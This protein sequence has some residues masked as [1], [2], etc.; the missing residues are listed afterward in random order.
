MFHDI[1][2]T[3]ESKEIEKKSCG[4]ILFRLMVHRRTLQENLFEN[5]RKVSL[6]RIEREV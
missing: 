3:P 5:G 1:C 4:A 2:I 6:Q